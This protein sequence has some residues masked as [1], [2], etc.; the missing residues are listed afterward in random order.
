MNQIVFLMQHI[1]YANENTDILVA[2]A[3]DHALVRE[4]VVNFLTIS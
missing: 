4:S 2:Y 3:E 1:K